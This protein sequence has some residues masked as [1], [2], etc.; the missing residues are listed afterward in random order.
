MAGPRYQKVDGRGARTSYPHHRNL[1]AKDGQQC[2]PALLFC[3]LQSHQT[4]S[5]NHNCRGKSLDGDLKLPLW[6]GTLKTMSTN[7]KCGGRIIGQS[8]HKPQLCR[9]NLRTVSINH[10]N[11]G[12][13]LDNVYK[14]QQWKKFI[15]QG[16]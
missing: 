2:H 5:T 16:Q 3:S 9:K 7:H 10:N 14:P 15:G 11:G 1:S 8:I 12:N 13:S 6:R 4:V